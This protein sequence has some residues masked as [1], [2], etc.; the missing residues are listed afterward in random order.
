MCKNHK[1]LHIQNTKRKNL[2]TANLS[3]FD[4]LG[5]QQIMGPRGDTIFCHNS[6]APRGASSFGQI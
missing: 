3:N 5:R 4:N 1:K 2:G 6:S